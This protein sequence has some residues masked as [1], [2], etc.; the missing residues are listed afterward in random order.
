MLTDAENIGIAVEI[1]LLSCL[2][3]VIYVFEVVMLPSWI[4]HFRFLPDWLYN[5]AAILIGKLDP[6]NIGKAVGM[7]LPSCLEAKISVVLFS[8]PV[9][10]RNFEFLYSA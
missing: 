8:H 1:S 4:F 2:E 3:T 6:E 10:C 5:I 7:S 9:Y